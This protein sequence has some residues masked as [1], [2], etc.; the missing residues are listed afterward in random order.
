MGRTPGRVPAAYV[1][2]GE[3]RMTGVEEHADD[4][5]R[6]GADVMLRFV[7][8]LIVTTL[9]VALTAYVLS[10]AVLAPGR[11]G[12]SHGAATGTVHARL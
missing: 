11:A 9:M 2:K 7:T 12:L 4:V 10:Y 3:M 1:S 8:T 6:V 5:G